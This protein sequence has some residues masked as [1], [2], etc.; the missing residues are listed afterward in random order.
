MPTYVY[1]CRCGERI[2]KT[3]RISDH[4]GDIRCGCGKTARQIIEGGF[5]LRDADVP[6]MASAVKV[7]Q[8]DNERP[9]QTR[10]EWRKYL[11]THQLEC[12][13]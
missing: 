1:L 8:P 3:C 4:V 9:V 11:K 13:G 2:E 5:T 7:L 6:W 12:T 10:Q